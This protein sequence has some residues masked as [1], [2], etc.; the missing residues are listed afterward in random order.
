MQLRPH[1]GETVERRA[2]Q[3]L[4]ALQLVVQEVEVPHVDQHQEEEEEEPS[5]VKVRA[6]VVVSRRPQQQ[7]QPPAAPP[8]A[9]VEVSEG[10]TPVGRRD[11]GT[12]RWWWWCKVASGD[13]V[14]DDDGVEEVDEVVE[15]LLDP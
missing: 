3:Q 12:G 5:K 7:Q 4:E 11:T 1:A 2:E 9:S 8:S 15:V 10:V 14:D 6:V 13:D